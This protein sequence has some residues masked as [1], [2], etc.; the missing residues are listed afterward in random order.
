[1]AQPVLHP[2]LLADSL[3]ALS[4]FQLALCPAQSAMQTLRRRFLR[5]WPVYALITLG[6]AFV[7]ARLGQGPMWSRTDIARRCAGNWAQN[8]LLV[9]AL[10]ANE[11]LPVGLFRCRT[12]LATPIRSEFAADPTLTIHSSKQCLDAGTL[13]ALEAQ[14]LLLSLLLMRLLAARPRVLLGVLATGVTISALFCLGAT[15]FWALPPA[16]LS[17]RRLEP[18]H[19]GPLADLLVLNPLARAGAPLVG[20]L[21][22]L[23][24]LPR[25][26][27][28]AQHL[29]R[30][31]PQ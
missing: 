7:F 3:L 2:T 25:I 15:L 22:S 9:C 30:A 14:F 21:F 4:A 10:L 29:L 11:W 16:L 24:L 28:Q 13:L 6:M 17:N 12:C 18:R 19:F 23:C 26:D 1:M 5:L 8:L 31:S 27:G 20:L